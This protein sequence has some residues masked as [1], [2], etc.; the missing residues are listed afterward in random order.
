M[1]RA[2]R[3]EGSHRTVGKADQPTSLLS[4]ATGVSMITCKQPQ[5]TKARLIHSNSLHQAGKELLQSPVGTVYL[6]LEQHVKGSHRS[7]CA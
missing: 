2:R 5:N 6:I 7:W 1:P 4:A 3:A